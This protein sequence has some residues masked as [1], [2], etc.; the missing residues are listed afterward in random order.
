M[1]YKSYIKSPEFYFW[2][3]LGTES[4]ADPSTC[5]F[6]ELRFWLRRFQRRSFRGFIAPEPVVHLLKPR[7]L[8]RLFRACWKNNPKRPRPIQLVKKRMEGNRCLVSTVYSPASFIMKEIH[9]VRLSFHLSE[10]SWKN[11][12]SPRKPSEAL[13]VAAAKVLLAS[14]GNLPYTWVSTASTLEIG[15]VMLACLLPR[16]KKEDC[17]RTSDAGRGKLPEHFWKKPRDATAQRH[18]K[19]HNVVN[20]CAS[21]AP[22]MVAGIYLAQFKKNTF[23][24][25]SKQTFSQKCPK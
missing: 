24:A 7:C 11:G 10:K 4:I 3:D 12:S 6:F 17:S 18:T 1:I 16:T 2:T 13:E 14:P 9:V 25:F 15:F 22:Y 5:L 23:L 8:S 20:R 19:W 21:K